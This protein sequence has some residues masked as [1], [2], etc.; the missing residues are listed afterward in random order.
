MCWL[1]EGEG[2]GKGGER[3]RGTESEGE[4]RG[5]RREWVELK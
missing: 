1:G 4:K 2:V 3:W 5:K